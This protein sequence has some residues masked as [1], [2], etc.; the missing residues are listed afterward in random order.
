[1]SPERRITLDKNSAPVWTVR[2]GENLFSIAMNKEV[3]AAFNAAGYTGIS[4]DERVN[5]LA[6]LNHKT[7]FD[8]DKHGNMRPYVI[9]PDDHIIL[10]VNPLTRF[11]Q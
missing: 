10:P 4:L 6:Q 9:Y 11:S 7:P 8:T 1:M 2:S 5:I 3:I